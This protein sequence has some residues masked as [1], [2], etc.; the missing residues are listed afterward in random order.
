MD[1]VPGPHVFLHPVG[2]GD[3]LVVPLLLYELLDLLLGLPLGRPLLRVRHP[4]Q[5]PGVVRRGQPQVRRVHLVH[6]VVP[7]VP[8]PPPRPRPEGLR[9][10][11]A[12]ARHAPQEEGQV[13]AVGAHPLEVR[14]LRLHLLRP[15]PSPGAPAPGSR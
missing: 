2:E 11:T 9:V 6:G 1:L 3:R 8:V 4:E 14:D 15:T 5:K 10:T 13:V 7:R 12:P